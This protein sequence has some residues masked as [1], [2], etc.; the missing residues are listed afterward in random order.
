MPSVDV[1]H[2]PSLSHITTYRYKDH[3]D[4]DKKEARKQLCLGCVVQHVYAGDTTSH[5]SS[6]EDQ[7]QI[8]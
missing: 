6:T 1:R 2:V 7:Q 8:D 4:R 5:E 3:E